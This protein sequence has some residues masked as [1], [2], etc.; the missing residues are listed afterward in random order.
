MI[1]GH[2]VL[3]KE[4]ADKVLTHALGVGANFAEIFV[5][6][7]F[8]SSIGLEDQRIEGVGDYASKGAGIRVVYGETTGFVHTTD[9]SEKGLME[10]AST[11]RSVAKG[12]PESQTRVVGL[13]KRYT[14]FNSETVDLGYFKQRA[15]E[16]LTLM[17]DIART[18]DSSIVQVTSSM[19]I[20]GRRFIL[21]NS[22]GRF[23]DQSTS[24]SR[25]AI[26]SVARGD[27]GLQTGYEPVAY[28]VDFEEF[29]DM[30]DFEEL[31]KTAS[32]RA[33]V[34]LA[35]KPAPSG[36]LPVVIRKGSGGVLFHEAC[37]HGL[38]ADHIKK[39]TSVYTGRLGQT[40][41]S[42]LVTLVDDGTVSKQWGSYAFDDEGAEGRY[43]V[44]I[45]N[46]VLEDYMW[47][48]SS[49]KSYRKET[50][51]NGRRQSYRHLPMV[52]M[53]NT[54]L[55][56]GESDPDDIVAHTEQG[57]YVSRLTGGQVNTATGD[58]VFGTQEAYLIENGEITSPLRDTQ[59]IG[60]GPE[61]LANIDM[62][63]RDFDMIPGSCGKNGQSVPVG[64]GQPTL[65]I[66][67][68]TLGGT[69]D[70]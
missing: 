35:A 55:L 25:V 7:S 22:D 68:I 63:G 21:A 46:G 28:T 51:G 49:A 59:L 62:V 26:K 42:P 20:H 16:K 66:S 61:V 38:E 31:A 39:N 14:S 17:D 10:A 52:R 50:S 57:V 27:T 5:E 19:N 15:K 70:V 4:T 32:Q 29:L 3:N 33:V 67:G 54:Y 37:G 36:T 12:S 41:A 56:P 69:A 24:R 43:N 45:R 58:F 23:V 1:R 64:T 65:R 48:A 8:S 9:L 47:D 13:S 60:N 34:K 30:M 44:L 40:V 18:V 11:A 2:L 53:T 6:D